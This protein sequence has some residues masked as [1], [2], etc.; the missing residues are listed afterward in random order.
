MINQTDKRLLLLMIEKCDRLIEIC[1]KHTLEEIESNYVYS[2]A[3]QFEFEKLYED[4]TRISGD[5]RI[6][7]QDLHIDNLRAI[8][9]RVAH[10]YESVSLKILIDTIKEDIPEIKKIMSEFLESQK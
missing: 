2:D 4:S 10:D 1:D 9:N 7:Y 3:I 5:L 8:R 6:N